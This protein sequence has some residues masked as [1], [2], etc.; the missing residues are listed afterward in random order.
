VLLRGGDQQRWLPLLEAE[1]PNIRQAF[2]TFEALGDDVHSLRLASA[3]KWFWFT[4]AHAREG[5]PRFTQV[6]ER[7]LEPT[8][9]RTEALVGAAMMAYAIGAY[10]QADRW[11]DEGEALAHALGE[12]SL[13]AECAHMRGAVEEHRGNEAGAEHA[14]ASGLAIAQEIG[15]AWLIGVLLGNLGDAA[16]RRGEVDLAEQHTRAAVPV[17]Q[18]TGNAFMESMAFVSLAQVALARGVVE[19]AVAALAQA[20]EIAESIESRVNRANSIAAT[21]AVCAAQGRWEQAVQLLGAADAERERSGSSHLPHFGLATQTEAAIRN[22]LSV[23]DYDR[24]WAEGQAL[25]S[26][27]AV[28]AVR[29]LFTAIPAVSNPLLT[30]SD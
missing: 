7:Y 20:L 29:A 10:D 21:A 8:S 3:L 12:R 25:S 27:D 22:A 14:F 28:A 1:H 16:Y 17:L 18:Q 13:L 9:L 23:E 2:A 30:R 15:D 24:G 4:H 11:L 26:G 19:Q 5:L 6:L